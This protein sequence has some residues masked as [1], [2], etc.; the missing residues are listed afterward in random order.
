MSTHAGVCRHQD[1]KGRYVHS[2]GYPSG[3]GVELLRL[4]NEHGYEKTMRTLVDEHYGWS[5]LGKDSELGPGYDDGRFVVVPDYG[6]AYTTVNGQSSSDNY[7]E[8]GDCEW[9]YLVSDG[10]ILVYKYDYVVGVTRQLGKIDWA[11]P[12]ATEEMLAIK[13]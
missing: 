12:S 8:L 6:V 3:V 7:T 9:T 2:D 4:L 5:S 10:F 13:E 11:S 1:G